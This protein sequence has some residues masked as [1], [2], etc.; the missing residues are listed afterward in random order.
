VE[1][2]TV[3]E[4]RKEHLVK[5]IKNYELNNINNA[6]RSGLFFMFPAFVIGNSA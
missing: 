3:E 6:D 2:S 5:T 1:S 4:W